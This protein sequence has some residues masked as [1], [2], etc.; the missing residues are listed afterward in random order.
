MRLWSLSLDNELSS[1]ACSSVHPRSSTRQSRNL[2]THL[3]RRQYG[4]RNRSSIL[5]S[6]FHTTCPLSSS[7]FF[8]RHERKSSSFLSR[9]SHERI[10]SD[11]SSSRKRTVSEND[12]N[13]RENADEHSSKRLCRSSEWLFG[14]SQLTLFKSI[15]TIDNRPSMVNEQQNAYLLSKSDQYLSTAEHHRR[16]S[17]DKQ[18]TIDTL[19]NLVLSR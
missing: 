2:L 5:A 11:G 1:S 12:E 4:L 9:L 17:S 7:S 8:P 16:Y 13:R 15:S 10:R 6:I 3:H 18:Q 14:D 19:S